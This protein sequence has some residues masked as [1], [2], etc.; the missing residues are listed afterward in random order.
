MRVG[1]LD[2]AEELQQLIVAL[3]TWVRVRVRV[4]ARVRV[5]VRVLV[6]VRISREG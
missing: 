6:R 4:T 3:V 5:R 2:E 1:P